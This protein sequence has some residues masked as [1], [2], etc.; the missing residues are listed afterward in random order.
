MGL[1]SRDYFRDGSYTDSLTG[2]GLHFTPV[3]KYLILANV[4]VFLLQIFITRRMPLPLPE[5]FAEEI[6]RQQA[7]LD[8]APAATGKADRRDTRREEIDRQKAEEYARK[9]KDTIERMAGSLP[10]LRVS[11]VQEWF[12]LAPH[13]TIEEFQLWRLVTSAF[14]HDRLAIWHI[15]VNMVLLYWFG[16]TLESM[17]GSREF[18]LFYL[19]AAVASSLAFVGLAYYTD[20]YVP[21]IG[22][23]GAVMG[24]MMLY[25]IHYPFQT[26]LIFWIF[27]LPIWMVLS[28]YVLYDLHPVLLALAGDQVNSTVAHAGHIGGLAFGFV[29]WKLG[30]RLEA[31]WQRCRV[32]RRRLVR[33]SEPLTEPAILAHPQRDAINERLDEVLQKISTQG[34]GSLTDEERAILLRASAKYR[35]DE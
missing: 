8:R 20:S 16:T 21:A 28:V 23:S 3:V 12:Q 1:E 15:L 5:D 32:P 19:A 7:Q 9:L 29:Y 4:V 17:Y 10:G 27:P 14:C 6:E 11:L 24:V 30:L 26:I 2:W 33:R 31:P 34:Q 25:T 18:L 35:G 13:E 22:A